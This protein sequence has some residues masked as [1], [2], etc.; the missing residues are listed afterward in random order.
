[1]EVSRNPE[2]GKFRCASITDVEY[3]QLGEDGG[4]VSVVTMFK[5]QSSPMRATSPVNPAESH[6]YT[7]SAS[8]S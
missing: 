1:M 8:C 5:R 4:F 3:A 7:V 6:S 2:N